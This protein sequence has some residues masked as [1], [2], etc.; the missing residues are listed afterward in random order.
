MQHKER[1]HRATQYYM[2]RQIYRKL[3]NYS[4]TTQTALADR[5]SDNEM[6]SSV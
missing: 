3:M 2:L 1:H 4:L 6:E 5:Q